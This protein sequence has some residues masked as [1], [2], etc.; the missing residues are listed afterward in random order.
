[1]RTRAN[2]IREEIWE[3]LHDLTGGVARYNGLS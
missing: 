3:N 1:M 2:M